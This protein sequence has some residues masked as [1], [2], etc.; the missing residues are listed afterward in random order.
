[1]QNKLHWAITGQ[2]AAELIYSSAD[3]TK[4]HMGLATW[5]HAPKGKSVP[6]LS[7]EWGYS[8]AWHNYTEEIQGRMLPRQWLTNLS[9]EVPLSIWYDW[10]DDGTDP[11]EGEHH[12][13]TVA[14][15]EFAGRDPLY[16]PKPAYLA[17]RRQLGPIWRKHFGN[18]YPAMSMIFV[19]DLLD[20]PGKIELEATAVIPRDAAQG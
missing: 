17:A 19:V 7:G 18:H 9:N 16:D 8:A 5:K 11:K 1:M 10:H 6:I 3:A 13:G 2:T 4:I 14:H 12:F 15:A 20:N